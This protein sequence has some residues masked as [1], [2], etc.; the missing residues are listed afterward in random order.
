M[1]FKQ[2]RSFKEKTARQAYIFVLPWLIGFLLFF[3][4]PLVELFYYSFNKVEMSSNG[5][6]TFTAVGFS[7]YKEAFFEN[8]KFNPLLSDA[9]LG[10]IPRMILVLIFSLIV[11]VLLNGKFVGRGL[12]RAV[13]FIPII[14]ASKTITAVVGGMQ[15]Q[16]ITEV[17]GQDQG[18][19]AF[20]TAFLARFLD[21]RTLHFL[22]N[23]VSTIFN[24]VLLS[25]VQ[26]LIFLSGLQAIS[27]SHYEVAKIEGASNYETF[28][29][30]TIPMISPM[31]L[32]AAVYTLA[33][34]FMT[35]ELVE[36]MNDIAFKTSNYGL[37]AA[38]SVVY[39][40][41]SLLI[42]TLV[43]FVISRR[44]YYND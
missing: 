5:G 33:E 30:V 35:A 43:S 18:N 6:L 9:V 40:L 14:M 13:F 26:T 22:L 10:S 44:V 32:I 21:P 8:T 38:M 23:S 27:N 20:L 4:K 3:I 24:T 39:L 15:A 12:A 19:I 36:Y 16:M 11:A 7:Q 1:I 34:H 41:V 29:R 25:G 42:V 17:S 28:W 37:S 2:K 31:I